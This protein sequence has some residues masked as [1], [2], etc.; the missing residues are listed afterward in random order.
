MIRSRNVF[1]FT[2]FSFSGVWLSAVP[3]FFDLCSIGFVEGEDEEG[4]AAGVVVVEEKGAVGVVFLV[5]DP[6][7]VLFSSLQPM[8]AK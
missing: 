8:Y 1:C 7:D 4:A 2:S 5:P 6:P 3:A